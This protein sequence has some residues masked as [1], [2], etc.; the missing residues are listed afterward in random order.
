M[1]KPYFMDNTICEECPDCKGYT[2]FEL[3]GNTHYRCNVTELGHAKGLPKPEAWQK[4]SYDEKKEIALYLFGELYELYKNEYMSYRHFLY[5]RLGFE[6]DTYSEFYPLLYDIYCLFRT[7]KKRT[8]KK[9]TIKEPVEIE[10]I[11]IKPKKT[12]AKQS[13]EIGLI[14][15]NEKELEELKRIL[16]GQ[17][18]QY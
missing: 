8:R 10:P 12:K 4:L 5:E 15:P 11:E 13:E 3:Y 2:E 7:T 14:I 9:Q 1:D 6:R 16:S 18:D 17:E